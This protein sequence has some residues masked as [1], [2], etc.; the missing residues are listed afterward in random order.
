LIAP[1]N[2]RGTTTA[3][4]LRRA[5]SLPGCIMPVNNTVIRCT[6]AAAVLRWLQPTAAGTL[7]Q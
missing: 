2:T 5:P 3:H 6:I 4:R 7:R 1:D